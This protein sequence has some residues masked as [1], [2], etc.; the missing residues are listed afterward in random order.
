MGG[1]KGKTEGAAIREKIQLL[2][3]EGIGIR[4]GRIMNFEEVLFRFSGGGSA[5]T[6]HP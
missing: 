3:E 2:K 4:G 6:P 5:D 1:F